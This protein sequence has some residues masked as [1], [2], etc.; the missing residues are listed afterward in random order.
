LGARAIKFKPSA[1]TL[2]PFTGQLMIVSAVNSLLV[3]AARNGT[4]LQAYPLETKLYK[5]PEGIAIGADRTL[6]ISNE[7]N[8]KGSANIMV[9]P[10]RPGKK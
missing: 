2:N 3:T 8:R 10:Y 4:I 1:T 7:W 6:Y 5:Q 9:I